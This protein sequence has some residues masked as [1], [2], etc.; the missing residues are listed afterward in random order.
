MNSSKLT[1]IL[2]AIVIALLVLDVSL[3]AY[4]NIHNSDPLT[5]ETIPETI[6]VIETDPSPIDIPEAEPIITEDPTEPPTE[7]PV[8]MGTVNTDRLNV[9]KEPDIDEIVIKQLAVGTRVEILE[10][11]ILDAIPWGRIAE[12]WINLRY[13]TM[14]GEE[15]PTVRTT[16]DIEQLHQLALINYIEAG[17][18]R[19]C[20]ECRRRVCDVVLNRVADTTRWPSED[21]I[22]KVLLSPTQFAQLSKTGLVWPDRADWME[23][24]H[25][26]ERAYIIAEEVLMG[27]HSEVYQQGYLWYQG[28][29]RTQDYFY[30]PDCGLVCFSR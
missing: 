27:K 4:V 30:C 23:E 7:P 11:K 24:Q 6:V 10:K 15:D 25:A 2:I 22:E 18:D 1:K 13:V 17:D 28:T 19:C 8:T 14:D 20:N 5:D 16:V 29:N 12:G 3:I 9:R 26:I 21:T